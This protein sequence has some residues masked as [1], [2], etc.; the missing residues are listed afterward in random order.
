[1]PTLRE[2]L[3]LKPG[4]NDPEEI[5]KAYRRQALKWHPDKVPQGAVAALEAATAQFQKIKEAYEA[6]KM[7]PNAGLDDGAAAAA[8]AAAVEVR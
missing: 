1:M 5:K 8:A 2:I 3:G 6:L 7:N 4:A